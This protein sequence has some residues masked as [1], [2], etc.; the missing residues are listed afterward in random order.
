MAEEKNEFEW[1]VEEA[2][3]SFK[4]DMNW[5][6]F[7]KMVHEKG[8]PFMPSD[9]ETRERYLNSPEFKEIQRMKRE[10]KEQQQEV[11]K[12]EYSGKMSIRMPKMLHRDLAVIAD[13]EGVSINKMMVV[14]LSQ[15]VVEYKQGLI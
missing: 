12:P 10:L 6:D 4:E 3:K 8:S 1:I 7:F 15:A 11:V 5:I 13:K 9:R 2:R 14:F